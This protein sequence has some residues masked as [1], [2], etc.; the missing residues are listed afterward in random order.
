MAVAKPREDF[1]SKVKAH[2]R[3][4]NTAGEVVPGATTVLGILNKPALVGWANRL[5]LQ[6]IDST[7]YVDEAA[8][9]GTLAHYLIQCELT[10]AEPELDD[11]TPAQLGRARHSLT[12]FHNWLAGKT[13]EPIFVER[14]LV[15]D[16]Y[17]FGGTI[18]LYANLDGVPTLL[19]FKT[20]SAIYPEHRF[21]VSAYAHL[22]IDHLYPVDG[23]RILKIGRGE[24][25]E[26]EEYLV[27]RP[28]IQRGWTI[29]QHA[30]AIYNL[31]KD[32]K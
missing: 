18:D 27:S 20:S 12:S 14:E 32:E 7:R 4:R 5:G 29:F 25:A 22:L 17:G 6:G 2:V 1:G 13:L 8:Q 3:Y 16:E 11:F 15:S 21:Q 10:G 30:L 26:I 28:Q 31:K 19:D 9:T 24:G 23:V